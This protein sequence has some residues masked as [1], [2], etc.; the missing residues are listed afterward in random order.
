MGPE[1]ER[2]CRGKV[3]VTNLNSPATVPEPGVEVETGVTPAC[4]WFKL[5]DLLLTTAIP[6]VELRPMYYSIRGIDLYTFTQRVHLSVFQT[7]QCTSVAHHP[8]PRR[9]LL[10]APSP[11]PFLPLLL[12]VSS[13]IGISAGVTSPV[14]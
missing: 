1:C 3:Q 8:P 7:C 6:L 9:S 2:E 4:G 10:R 14:L 13:I 11:F 5:G 12:G